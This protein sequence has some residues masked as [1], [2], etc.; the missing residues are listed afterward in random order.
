M[1]CPDENALN[2][3]LAGSLSAGVA[4][5]VRSHVETCESCRAVMI[6][7]VRDTVPAEADDVDPSEAGMDVPGL[8]GGAFGGRYVPESILGA[9]AMGLVYAGRDVRLER[10][11]AIKVLIGG[12]EGFTES[13]DDPAVSAAAQQ[14]LSRVRREARSLAQ[15]NHPNVAAVYD[16][17][18][19]D[20]Q[21][22]IAMELVGGDTLRSWVV[23]NPDRPWPSVVEAYVQAARG[24]AA[25]HAAGI[26]HRDFKPDNAMIDADGRVRVLDFGLASVR[27]AAGGSGAAATLDNLRSGTDET[28]SHAGAGT[29]AYMAPEC[30]KGARADPSGDQFSLCVSLWEALYGQPPFS[31]KTL[32]ALI[33]SVESGRLE[34]VPHDTKVPERIRRA[35]ARG[36]SVHP[37]QRWPTLDALCHELRGTE[38]G[39][40]RRV[41]VGGAAV[42]G[43]SA[44]VWGAWPVEPPSPC[45]EGQSVLA[46]LWGPEQREGVRHAIVDV[47]TPLASRTWA[48]VDEQI[49]AYGDRWT[50]IKRE[51]CEASVGGDRASNEILDLKTRCLHRAALGLGAATRALST[52]D[53][54]TALR[55]DRVLDGLPSLERCEDVQALSAEVEPPPPEEAEAVEQIGVVLADAQAVLRAGKHDRARA[56]GEQA[57]ERAAALRYEPVQTRIL[58]ISANVSAA[59]G[60]YS[61]AAESARQ[62][63]DLATQWR[64]RDD[65]SAAAMSLLGLLGHH[66]ASPDEA[67]RYRSLALQLAQ[68]NPIRHSKVEEML[69]QLDLRSGKYEE[70]EL[71]FRRILAFRVQRL[72]AEHRL[73]AATHENLGNALMRQ[74]KLVEAEAEYRRAL[75]VRIAAYGEP[76]P[77]VATSRANLAALF[78]RQG[79]FAEA[80]Q[81]NRTALAMREQLLGPLHP[82]VATSYNNLAISLKGQGKASEAEEAYRKALAIREKTLRADHRD[83]ALLRTNLA[84]VIFLQ[85]R[86]DEAVVVNRQALGELERELGAEHPHVALSLNNFGRMLQM[87]GQASEAEPVYR[88]VIAMRERSGHA[89]SALQGITLGNL[90]GV[91]IG[92]ERFADARVELRAAAQLLERTLGPEHRDTSRIRTLLAEA[93]LLDGASGQARVLAEQTWPARDDMETAARARL[94]YVLMRATWPT[95]PKGKERERARGLAAVA[96]GD[97]ESVEDP[98][99]AAAV[100]GWR[101]HAL[102]S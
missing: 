3:L 32:V 86:H 47:D 33:D 53:A 35:L 28:R 55:A 75:T 25:A 2:A 100:R 27:D 60:N 9:G 12:T 20:R 10:T 44:S 54:E 14:A 40:T 58:Q 19:H 96:I 52:A 49:T 42:I 31:G 84:T 13:G 67:M 37:T 8:E 29:P 56:L 22:F 74:A 81:E 57:K 76:H 48:R 69:A 38:R 41:L 73:V 94:A 43:V 77:L 97:Y 82:D 63:L 4:D 61:E 16:V 62:A 11:V 87:M 1:V 85:G 5:G 90:G 17:G 92:A 45:A 88:R 99:G 65:Q 46:K 34:A 70:S 24:L 50:T 66:Q 23:D 98:T 89:E 36:L 26:V 79:R 91:L 15:L 64:Q 71:V 51:A 59:Q 80:E 39:R 83:I 7:V 21:M 95:P 68:D 30:L 18:G 78:E 6:A 72:G 101:D 102:G 93:L